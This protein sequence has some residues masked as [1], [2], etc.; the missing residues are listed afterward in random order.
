[1][2]RKLLNPDA[3]AN[4]TLKLLKEHSG[5][6]DG[7][8]NACKYRVAYTDLTTLTAIVIQ[9][10]GENVTVACNTSE[11]ADA[12]ACLPIIRAALHGAGYLSDDTPGATPKDL[13]LF[14]DDAGDTFIDF[15]G[16]AKIVSLAV[17]AGTATATELCTSY[18]DCQYQTTVDV[19]AV[20]FAYDDAVAGGG[21]YNTGGAATLKAAILA[22]FPNA[23][24]ATVTEAAS[25]YS[26]SFRAAK[27]EVS[28]NGSVISRTDCKQNFKA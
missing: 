21:T 20:S 17:D 7:D 12:A 5:C 3:N 28:F 23:Y 10:G 16:E 1:M 11:A 8:Y 13:V 19:G 22:Y 6:C 18:V 4:N 27:H 2:F 9:E 15:W 14:T 26:I 24:S 25:K